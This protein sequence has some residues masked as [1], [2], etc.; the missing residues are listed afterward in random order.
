MCNVKIGFP[1]DICYTQDVLF[2]LLLQ[3][4]EMMKSYS[5]LYNFFWKKQ[6]KQNSFMLIRLKNN[7]WTIVKKK[8]DYY[9]YH[10]LKKK[11]AGKNTSLQTPWSY[12]SI[13]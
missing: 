9:S 3:I 6:Q 12:L 8:E 5:S 13:L 2:L 10:Y 1:V 4:A 11:E 7:L